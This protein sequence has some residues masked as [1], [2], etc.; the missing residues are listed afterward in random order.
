MVLA[1]NVDVSKARRGPF[2]GLL[3]KNLTKWAC[4]RFQNMLYLHI[5]RHDM[6]KSCT[7]HISMM[8]ED[9]KS[10]SNS[11]HPFASKITIFH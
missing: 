5:Y 10:A 11:K 2:L 4:T 8:V 9:S 7:Q 6:T 1:K 3:S